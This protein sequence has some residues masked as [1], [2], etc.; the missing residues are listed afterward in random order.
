MIQGTA[1]KKKRNMDNTGQVKTRQIYCVDCWS[2]SKD[3]P[4]SFCMD[5]EPEL[6]EFEVAVV[7]L[8]EALGRE[9]RFLNSNSSSSLAPRFPKWANSRGANSDTQNAMT[10]EMMATAMTT[11]NQRGRSCNTK[12][13]GRDNSITAV[14]LYIQKA[15]WRLS[16]YVET[17]FRV[18]NAR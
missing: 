4:G 17:I 13:T 1:E 12:A 15:I 5:M 9:E 14:K 8:G 2:I 18:A 16:L 7:V 11:K 6:S 3:Q 10:M